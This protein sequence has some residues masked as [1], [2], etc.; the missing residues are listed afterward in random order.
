MPETRSALPAPSASDPPIGGEGSARG[1]FRNLF[2]DTL[3]QIAGGLGVTVVNVGMCMAAVR[4][5]G[6][7]AFGAFGLVHTV[8]VFCSFFLGFGAKNTLTI[9]A[10]RSRY[11]K[12]DTVVGSCYIYLVAT[13][14]ATWLL[15]QI[16]PPGPGS[17]LMSGL[18][19]G[20]SLLIVFYTATFAFFPLWGSMLRGA[21]RHRSASVLRFGSQAALASGV[22][23]GICFGGDYVGAL[24]GGAVG[25]CLLAVGVTAVGVVRWGF[26]LPGLKPFVRAG[27][28][29]GVRSY[30][31]S[32]AEVT[33]EAFGIFYLAAIGDLVGVAAI[34]GCQR[35]AAVLSKP[36]QIVNLV[37]KGKVAGQASGE[38]EAKRVLQLSRFTFLFG[39]LASLPLLLFAR[40]FTLLTLGKGFEDAV[41]VMVLVLLTQ[42][43]RAHAAPACGF[44]VGKGCPTVY[45]VLRIAVLAWTVAGVLLLGPTWGAVGVALVQCVISLVTAVLVSGVLAGEAKSVRS[46]FVGDDLLLL[47]RLFVLRSLLFHLKRA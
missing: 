24:W 9:L 16:D 17:R 31:A 29:V 34:V 47:G 37:L 22:I 21:D 42:A 35:M 2:R 7:D 26:R 39:V 45:L 15:V 23:L 10:G 13:A 33:V 43:L 3:W 19:P 11:Q 4:L 27:A 12:K 8:A 20:L 28:S 46:V 36:A 30:L 25:M 40:R 44:L 5:L 38:Q 6:R 14:I 32:V 1:P 18:S 41:L